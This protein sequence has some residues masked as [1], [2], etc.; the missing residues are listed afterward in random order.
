MNDLQSDA[1]AVKPIEQNLFSTIVLTFRSKE[2]KEVAN[3]LFKPSLDYS[4]YYYLNGIYKWSVHSYLE[5][6]GRI[7]VE[8]EFIS[9]SAQVTNNAINSLLN[10][11]ETE[12]NNAINSTNDGRVWE[13]YV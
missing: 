10:T 11:I 9:S 2:E 6:A 5:E 3:K 7:Q 1:I 12:V 8:L 13:L 4:D